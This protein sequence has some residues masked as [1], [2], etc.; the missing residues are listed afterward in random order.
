MNTPLKCVSDGQYQLYS[1]P[2]QSTRCIAR[3]PFGSTYVKQMPQMNGRLADFHTAVKSW[4]KTAR[5][6][7]LHILTS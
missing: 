6:I 5:P 1:L 2:I 7:A 3:M 4:D